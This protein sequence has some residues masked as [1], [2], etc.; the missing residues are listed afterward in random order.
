M[1]S[2][3]ILD[4][5]DDPAISFDHEGICNYCH[6]YDELAETHLMERK[7]REKKLY[8]IVNQIKA[9]RKNKEY[10]C[11][12]GL[13]GG[14][15]SSYLAYKVKN[16]GLKPLVVHYDNGWN[17][18]LAVMNIEH[19]VSQ[20]GFD[21]YTYVNNWEEF[22]DIQLAFLKAS[23]IDI[24]AI[25]DQG[26]A[27][28][29]DILARKKG[30][31]YILSGNNIVTEAILPEN[32]YHWKIDVLNIKAIHKKFGALKMKTYPTINFYQRLFMHYFPKTKVIPLLNYM[33]YNRNNA[34]QMLEVKLGWRDYGGKHYE[35]IF[36]RFYQGYILPIKFNVDKRKAHLSTMICSQQITRQQALEEMKKPIYPPTQ[37]K[38]DK[39]FVLKKLGLSDDEFEKIMKLPIKKHT[40]Y[41]SYFNKHYKYQKWFAR[42]IGKLKRLAVR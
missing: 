30:I 22:K 23:V 25:T 41:P 5:C 24:E 29:L 8:E 18:E 10:D 13:S 28:T 38:E 39:E 12:L 37:L 19:I 6:Q 15:D 36:T 4:T 11:I 14:V 16:L 31:N 3:C 17:S 26:I 7:E 42:K 20:L 1:C 33:D 21:L 2:K 9:S 35:S 32:W 27:A 34:K 40:D